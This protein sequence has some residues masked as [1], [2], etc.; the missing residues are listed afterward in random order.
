M[1]RA[2]GNTVLGS[3][4]RA[5][6]VAALADSADEQLLEQFVVHQDEAAFAALVRRHGPMVWGI[7]Q[8]LVAHQQD[9]EDCF[10]ATFLVLCCK[11]NSIGRSKLLA[12]WLFGVARRAALNAQA[13]RARRSRHETLCA[14]LPD[15]P[16]VQPIPFDDGAS[17]LDHELARLP[18]R[19]R[20]PLLLCGL[21][22]M[23]H[24]QAGKSLGWPVGTVAGRLSRA[25]ELLRTRLERRGITAPGALLPVLAAVPSAPASVPPELAAASV[26]SAMALFMAGRS[27][28]PDIPATV[29]SLV[30]GVLHKMLLHRVLT[31]S[32]AT[33]LAVLALGGAVETWQFYLAAETNLVVPGTPGHGAPAPHNTVGAVTGKPMIRLPAN[34]DE[35][36]LRMDRLIDAGTTP[37]ARL[38]VFA[39]GRIQVEVPEGL[40]SLSAQELTKFLHGRKDKAKESKVPEP[41]ILQGKLSRLELDELMRFAV[42]DQEFM[43]LD[44]ATVKAAISNE[45]QRDG[46]VHDDT[47]ATT[48]VFMVQTAYSKREVSWTQLARSAWDFPKVRPLQQLRGMEQRLAHLYYVLLAGGSE[49]VNSVVDEMDSLLLTYYLNHPEIPRLTTA[50]LS[51]VSPSAD[52]S[53]IR[54]AFTRPK[55]SFGFVPQFAVSIAIPDRGLPFIESLIPPQ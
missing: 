2:D 36:V 43:T 21:E 32:M 22:G 18:S 38:T 44:A 15:L 11:A 41:K 37:S 40:G 39:D 26:R 16:G 10:Q 4:R 52:G 7:C 23:T 50:D 6:S 17:V 48:T 20:L 29:T 51:H 46:T 34:P 33:M 19:Y 28:S 13:R 25:R 47:D 5:L 53:A 45:Y 55:P 35:V 30:R 27:L 8:R 9:A 12:N 49:R 3:L 14:D 31:R 42:I 54:Y 24:S 1:K